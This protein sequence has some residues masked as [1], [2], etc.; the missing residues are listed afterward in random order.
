MG[1]AFYISLPR[2]KFFLNVAAV[3]TR[4][5]ITYYKQP[6]SAP[7][8]TP[9]CTLSRSFPRSHFLQPGLY[10]TC[11][12]SSWSSSSSSTS[13]SVSS[14]TPSLTSGVKNRRKKKSWRR[15]AS[16]AVRLL[17]WSADGRLVCFSCYMVDFSKSARQQNLR[18]CKGWE[19]WPYKNFTIFLGLIT[20]HIITQSYTL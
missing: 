19:I 4:L 18:V 17:N 16:S 10:T 12:S 5:I 15:L 7:R 20:V 1:Q 11:C 2:H 14:S 8:L 6:H 13:S 9:L 3:K